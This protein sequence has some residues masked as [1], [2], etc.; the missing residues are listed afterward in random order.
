LINRPV[1]P[2][3][4]EKGHH[5]FQH[6]IVHK[7]VVT[8]QQQLPYH[9]YLFPIDYCKLV[10][11][12][13]PAIIVA[14]FSVGAFF[15][16][17]FDRPAFTMAP[18]LQMGTDMIAIVA[19]SS[20][21]KDN[22]N[23]LFDAVEEGVLSLPG[24]AQRMEHAAMVYGAPEGAGKLGVSLQFDD[25][26][27]TDSPRWAAGWVIEGVKDQFHATQLAQEAK[28]AAGINEEIRA[29]RI[30]NSPVM[31]AKIP[32]RSALTP[33]LAPKLHWSRGF[34]AFNKAFSKEEVGNPLAVEIFVTGDE[35]KYV[36]I[37]FAILTD[38]KE[39]MHTAF[40]PIIKER[41]AEERQMEEQEG[42][43]QTEEERHGQEE[44]EQRQ[45]SD[46]EH[47]HTEDEQHYQVDAQHREEEQHEEEHHDEEYHEDDHH[48]E[49]HHEDHHD[50][51]HHEEDHH[52]EDHHD[53]DH[54]DE[55][56]HD[57]YHHD[58]D[59]HDEDHHDE[60]HHDDEHHDEEDEHSHHD[61][62]HGDVASE[63]A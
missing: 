63:V 6:H 62:E 7:V 41:E 26:T 32:W 29:V 45:W 58:E 39:T 23:R 17:L 12:L 55:D 1:S 9:I 43:G 27:G 30:K 61:E 50:Q 38:T 48:E 28:N 11:M 13:I 18:Q 60:D 53:E 14:L 4:S 31:I 10:S 35:G 24:G 8:S 15:L 56:H 25:P 42:N 5:L 59:H 34:S 36:S 20:A 47:H 19:L 21:S 44:E 16:G 54:H 33:M 49:E 2:F 37:D 51:D 22:L 57:E 52:E 46:E 3:G 40:G